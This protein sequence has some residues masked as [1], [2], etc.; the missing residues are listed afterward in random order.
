MQL[1]EHSEFRV[2]DQW[3][4]MGGLQENAGIQILGIRSTFPK[5]I[6]ILLHDF[7]GREFKPENGP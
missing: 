4:I 6:K 7:E 1:H 5:S 3:S 2:V